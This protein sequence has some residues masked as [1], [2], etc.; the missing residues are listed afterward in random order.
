MEAS[1]DKEALVSSEIRSKALMRGM[2]EHPLDAWLSRARTRHLETSSVRYFT[3]TYN[4]LSHP[5]TRKNTFLLERKLG[6]NS[7]EIRRKVSR[8]TLIR[9]HPRKQLFF[10]DRDDLSTSFIM[11]DD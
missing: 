10:L 1:S 3:N 7:N 4:R 6:S 8:L 2:M 11:D 5:T 9:P